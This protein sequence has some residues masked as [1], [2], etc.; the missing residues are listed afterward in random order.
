MLDTTAL[1]ALAD[2]VLARMPQP[3]FALG[4]IALD[5]AEYELVERERAAQD[6][7]SLPP[8][9]VAPM[10]TLAPV[11]QND[12]GH[13]EQWFDQL[14]ALDSEAP[15][16]DWVPQ[17]GFAVSAYRLS[18][19]GLIG[20]AGAENRHGVAASLAQL[21]MHW[22]VDA[23]FEAVQRAGVAYMSRGRL[24]PQTPEAQATPA[25]SRKKK[26]RTA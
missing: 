1:A 24:L 15:L 9:Q 6:D 23:E 22:H 21:P 12:Y 16:S 17:D 14:A 3:A 10:E 18:L 7:A 25:P 2:D 5:V 4:P 19:L 11:V 13:A 26:A 20:D 8:S